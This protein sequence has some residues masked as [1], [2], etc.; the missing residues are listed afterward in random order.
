MADEIKE[1]EMDGAC[2]YNMHARVKKCRH[3]LVRKP[4]GKGSCHNYT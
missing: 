1:D 3:I 4:E 2:T